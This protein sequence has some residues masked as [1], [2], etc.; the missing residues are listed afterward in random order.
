MARRKGLFGSLF[1]G[2]FKRGPSLQTKEL[3]AY[4]AFKRTKIGAAP[5]RRK[6]RKWF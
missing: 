5:K 1:S 4:R 3:K 6:K 2:L